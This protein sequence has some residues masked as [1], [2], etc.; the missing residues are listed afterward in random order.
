VNKLQLNLDDLD[1]QTFHTTPGSARGQG[2]VHGAQV[3]AY[4]GQSCYL[5]FCGSCDPTNPDIDC[6]SIDSNGCPSVNVADCPTVMYSCGCSGDRTG[7][8]WDRDEDPECS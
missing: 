8:V 4:W 3:T 2:T 6:G 5:T 7:P 1:V